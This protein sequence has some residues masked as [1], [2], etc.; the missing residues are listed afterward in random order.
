MSRRSSTKFKNVFCQAAKSDESFLDLRN[1]ATSGE[2]NYIAASSKYFS[3][4]RTG[5]GGPV[6]VLA[7]DSPGRMEASPNLLSVGKGKTLDMA[8]CPF[9]DNM[10]ATAGEDQNISIT[11]IPDGGMTQT[12]TEA[13]QV[14]SGH[15]KKVSLL[16]WNPIANNIISS[17]GYDKTVRTWDISTGAEI[18][19]F[20]IFKDN[21]YSLA[22]SADGSQLASTSKDKNL[23]IYDPRSG[24]ASH[25]LSPFDGGKSSKVWWMPDK[26]MLG[27]VGFSR[28]AKRQIRIYDMANTDKPI[29]KQD[30][31]NNSSVIMPHYDQDTSMLYMPAKGDGSISWY[32][33][34]KDKRMLY[35]TQLGYRDVVP[36]KGG[37]FLPKRACNVMT[38]EINRFLKLTKDS[39]IPLSFIAPRKAKQFQP[40]LYPDAHAGRPALQADEWLAGGN[41]DPILMSLDPNDGGCVQATATTTFEKKKSYAELNQENGSLKKANESLTARVKELE[42]QLAEL[43]S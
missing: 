23:Y 3:V 9:N 35:K 42:E 18:S 37:C 30:L 5:G 39:V 11:I 32:E 40:D 8:W 2:S 13:N 15:E 20:D 25:T 1:P 6:Y 26:N 10:V 4:A 33:V 16:S 36:Q 41:A 14:C 43:V 31:D 34:K 28:G 22:W 29:L 19:C 21:V 27:A 38:C 24:E 7:H 12:I 17:A